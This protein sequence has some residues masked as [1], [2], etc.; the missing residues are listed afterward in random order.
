MP[1]II[2]A[3]VLAKPIAQS[4]VRIA[5]STPY[6]KR[7]ITPRQIQENDVLKLEIGPQRKIEMDGRFLGEM[8]WHCQL[9]SQADIWME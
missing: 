6:K 9:D 2:S 5:D 7:G 4:G 8:N 1:P 3:R